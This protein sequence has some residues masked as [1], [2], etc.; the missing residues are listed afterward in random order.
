MT[1]GPLPMM[2]MVSRSVRLRHSSLPPGGLGLRHQGGEVVEQVAGVVRTGT[3]LGM[4]LHAERRRVEHPEALD[5]AVVEVH[6]G[7]LHAVFAD[8]SAATA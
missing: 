3:R 7:E 1:I 5:H 4:V 2:R 8:R 6:V